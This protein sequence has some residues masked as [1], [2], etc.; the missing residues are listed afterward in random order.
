VQRAACS[1]EVARSRS[2]ST[3]AAASIAACSGPPRPPRHR[4]REGVQSALL[5]SRN[6]WTTVER[7][8]SS[9]SAAYRWADLSGYDKTGQVS[10]IDLRGALIGKTYFTS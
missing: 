1:V 6:A 9:R 10:V 8:T 7:V 5:G 3:R 4:H 2:I